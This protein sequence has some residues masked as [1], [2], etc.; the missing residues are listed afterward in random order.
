MP[1]MKK[2]QLLDELKRL[3][4]E[5]DENLKYH[6]LL[7]LLPDKQA[8]P[9]TEPVVEPEIVITPP[10]QPEPVVE[11]VKESVLEFQSVLS[12]SEAQYNPRHTFEEYQLQHFI[13][14]NKV[15]GKVLRVET[16]R[17]YVPEKNGSFITKYKVFKKE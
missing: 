3:G 17:S 9:A 12:E 8:E 4:I 16:I 13:L 2:P 7:K 6:E 14:S 11:T 5:F 1:L 15:H 10:P